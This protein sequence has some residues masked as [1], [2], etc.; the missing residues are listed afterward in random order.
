LWIYEELYSCPKTI[1]ISKTFIG[2]HP[3]ILAMSLGNYRANVLKKGSEWFLFHNIPLELDPDETVHA[4]F[5]IA[6]GLS[7]EQ[8]GLEK[9]ITTS[10]LY[11]GLTLFVEV[12]GEPVLLNMEPVNTDVFKF[13]IDPRGVR[14]LKESGFDQLSLFMLSLREGFEDLMRETCVE[15]GRRE[16]NTCVIPTSV[17]ELIVST[18]EVVRKG[19]MRIIPDNAPLRHVVKV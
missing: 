4:C 2:V 14:T 3:G 1:L 15:I 13:Y 18:K 11:G 6:K 5:Q 17:G 12:G 16:G 10:M 9:V 19:L 8:K 7:Y